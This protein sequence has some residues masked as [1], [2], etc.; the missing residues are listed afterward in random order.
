MAVSGCGQ[1][2][3][4]RRRRSCALSPGEMMMPT[5]LLSSAAL[6]STML[7]GETGA[8]MC[9]ELVSTTVLTSFATRSRAPRSRPQ[10]RGRRKGEHPAVL[11]RSAASPHGV[12]LRPRLPIAPHTDL[13]SRSA[14]VRVSH[15]HPCMASRSKHPVMGA[16]HER[17]GGPSRCAAWPGV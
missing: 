6:A 11:S 17:R 7:D 9:I 4:A 14:P 1:R 8:G 16:C 10:R 2:V 3:T 13:R 15:R 12:H 5:A